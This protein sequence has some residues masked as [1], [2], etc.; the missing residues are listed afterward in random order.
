MS[1]VWERELRE[2]IRKTHSLED[3]LKAA[4][5]DLED[6]RLRAKEAETELG[7]T[8]AELESLKLDLVSAQ[9]RAGVYRE[10]L[11][12]LY[13]E[14]NK[15]KAIV[16]GFRDLHLA[17]SPAARRRSDEDERGWNHRLSGLAHD[18]L[19][20]Y[21][22]QVILCEVCDGL[23]LITC[24]CGDPEHACGGGEEVACGRCDGEGELTGP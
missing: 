7:Q 17:R 1:E 6:F 16:E 24:D 4:L 2:E 15:A 22:R 19:A 21:P 18:A 20:L 14:L 13:P 10:K 8:R 12:A 23:G 11:K 5:E 3:Q 9:G